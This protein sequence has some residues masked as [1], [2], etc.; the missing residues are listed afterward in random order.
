M[1][2]T[3][4]SA[5]HASLIHAVPDYTVIRSVRG[6]G[7]TLLVF[8]RDEKGLGSIVLPEEDYNLAA[9][10]MELFHGFGKDKGNANR[11]VSK[12]GKGS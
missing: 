10:I 12:D 6:D 11:G 8:L 7:S 1:I 9:L 4:N 5:Q 2:Q 3:R